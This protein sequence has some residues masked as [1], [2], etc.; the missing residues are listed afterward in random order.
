MYP[1][2]AWQLALVASLLS[3]LAASYIMLLY[4]RIPSLRTFPARLNASLSAIDLAWFGCGLLSMLVSAGDRH[5]TLCVVLGPVYHACSLAS[6]GFLVVLATNVALMV[7]QRPMLELEAMHLRL[8]NI[9]IVLA[10]LPPIVLLANDI[11]IF[12]L[13]ADG[14]RYYE[15]T[16]YGTCFISTRLPGARMALQT[17]PAMVIAVYSACIYANAA[18]T[19]PT[20]VGASQVASVRRRIVTRGLA[21]VLGFLLCWLLAFAEDA[22]LLSNLTQ[23]PRFEVPSG[24]VVAKSLLFFGQGLWNAVVYLINKWA[25]LRPELNSLWA[26]RALLAALA[27]CCPRSVVSADEYE[28]AALVAG[29]QGGPRATTGY[30]AAGSVPAAGRGWAEEE[31]EDMDHA[32][33]VFSPDRVGTSAP[34]PIAAARPAKQP[35]QPVVPRDLSLYD[36]G[37]VTS[38]NLPRPAPASPPRSGLGTASRVS[39]AQASPVSIK[40]AGRASLVPI[41]DGPSLDD[42]DDHQDLSVFS[43]PPRDV[44]AAAL[45]PAAVDAVSEPAASC[46]VETPASGQARRPH[47]PSISTN[48][49]LFSEHSTGIGPAALEQA[50]SS[51][52]EVVDRAHVA[53]L[54][55]AEPDTAVGSTGSFGQPRLSNADT[56]MTSG[57][58]EDHAEDDDFY[59]DRDKQMG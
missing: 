51:G 7:R 22:S 36:G 50:A 41:A 24:L 43:T 26:G 14:G 17:A 18:Y 1:A 46:A 39:L 48:S 5:Q 28:A 59:N 45:Q 35:A 21:Y 20:Y 13:L 58:D 10:I 3:V 8:R 37:F 54:A 9:V 32:A 57:S 12:S 42:S 6:M 56:F 38:A 30:G 19:V 23:D 31:A 53:T 25:R 55:V 52:Q 33:L 2:A 34:Q 4:W 11:G 47:G 29:G 49:S 44:S 16:P 27:V 15:P 40:E